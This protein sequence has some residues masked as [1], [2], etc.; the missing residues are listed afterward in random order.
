MS[1]LFDRLVRAPGAVGVGAQ[2]NVIAD[3]I[4]NGGN[5]SDVIARSHFYLDLAQAQLRHTL[6]E[7]SGVRWL[8]GRDNAAVN[9]LVARG[10][11][12]IAQRA[13]VDT[14]TP[15]KQSQL[16]GAKSGVPCDDWRFRVIIA[17][18]VRHHR[19]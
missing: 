13:A 4:A 11:K 18:P 6:G 8:L 10:W 2:V 9:D 16:D 15:I 19:S 3:G 14:Q 12:K 7:R 5:T 17:R 1:Q